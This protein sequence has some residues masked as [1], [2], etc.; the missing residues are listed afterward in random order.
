V[1]LCDHRD[2]VEWAAL[3]RFAPGFYS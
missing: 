2:E 3:F 1:S